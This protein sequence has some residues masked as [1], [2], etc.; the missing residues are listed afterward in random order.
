MW[1][2]ELFVGILDIF[3]GPSDE[4]LRNIR[5]KRIEDGWMP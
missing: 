1:F 2:L 3:F 5:E 4:E